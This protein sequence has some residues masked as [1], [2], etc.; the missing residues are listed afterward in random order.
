MRQNCRPFFFPSR[1]LTYR[2]CGLCAQAHPLFRSAALVFG[3]RL[4]GVVL[5]GYL[6]DGTAGLQA[7]KLCGGAAI[8]Q[9]P[10]EAVAPGMPLSALENAHVDFCLPL[11]EI[12]PSIVPPCNW[13]SLQVSARPTPSPPALRPEPP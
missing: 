13:T 1:A 5:T 9:D 7:V 10:K 3:P 12:G 4:I 2:A 6:D 8:V 11:A